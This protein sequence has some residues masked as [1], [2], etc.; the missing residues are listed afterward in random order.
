[1]KKNHYVFI[2][3]LLLTGLTINPVVSQSFVPAVP[4]SGAIIV[5]ILRDP[6]M[7][8]GIVP[9][10]VI[11]LNR[12]QHEGVITKAVI[13]DEPVLANIKQKEYFQLNL[14]ANMD[15]IIN[16][17]AGVHFILFDGKPGSVALL[18][19]KGVKS[20]M[21]CY[22]GEIISMSNSESELKFNAD[23]QAEGKKL[24]GDPSTCSEPLAKLAKY[25]PCKL[26][27]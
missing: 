13:Q 19:I 24:A 11:C 4:D 7:T 3:S 23:L 2:L 6:A 27:N 10:P 8:G 26:K 5:Y 18:T 15:Y 14:I 17:G 9:W 22:S 12:S 21:S 1:M 16:V 25:K 20:Y